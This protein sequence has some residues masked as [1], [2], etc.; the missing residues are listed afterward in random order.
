VPQPLPLFIALHYMGPQPYL[1]GRAP[2]G[3]VRG[4]ESDSVSNRSRLRSTQ[5]QVVASVAVS[6]HMVFYLLC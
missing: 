4:G 1:V 6:V 3:C 5:H 2:S